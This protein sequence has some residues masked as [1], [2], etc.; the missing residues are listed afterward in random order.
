M[1]CYV[2]PSIDAVGTCVNCG[3]AVCTDCATTVAGKI[4][5]RDCSAS[6]APLQQAGK[7]NGLAIAS[8]VLGIVS[9]PMSFCY[10]GGILF[11]IPAF[12]M[13]LVARR[14]IK[15]SGNTQSGDGMALAGMITGGVG[16]L[17]SLAFIAILIFAILLSATGSY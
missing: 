9:V 7:T 15:E 16:V 6:G 17:G 10:G 14:Q 8:L 11:A 12:I 2:H 1:N 5:C 13:G 4:Y 3:K